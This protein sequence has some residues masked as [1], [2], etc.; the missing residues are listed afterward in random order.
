MCL[1]IP[2][3]SMDASYPTDHAHVKERERGRGASNPVSNL[4]SSML[5]P[6]TPFCLAPLL[7]DQQLMSPSHLT[8]AKPKSWFQKHGFHTI[9]TIQSQAQLA[10]D[11]A[12]F[13]SGGF[14]PRAPILPSI[15]TQTCMRQECRT[16]K[17]VASCP[18]DWVAL[19]VSYEGTRSFIINKNRW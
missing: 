6:W 5:E 18:C 8:L 4:P 9:D 12:W 3:L 13:Q 1:I 16:L 14:K 19:S 11:V 7:Y 10:N 2:S 17:S 15:G